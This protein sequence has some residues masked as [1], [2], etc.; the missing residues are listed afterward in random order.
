MT[1]S[2][3]NLRVPPQV[4]EDARAA[5]YANRETLA[6]RDDARR[7][8]RRAQQQ[9]DAIRRVQPDLGRQRGGQLEFERPPLQRLWRR[10]GGRV[11][12]PVDVGV[13]WLATDLDQG[14]FLASIQSIHDEAIQNNTCQLNT[15]NNYIGSSDGS[16][17][18]VIG[19]GS[20]YVDSIAQSPELFAQ[21]AHFVEYTHLPLG[22][23]AM[24]AIIEIAR[25]ESQ[26]VPDPFYGWQIYNLRSTLKTF[27]YVVAESSVQLI[28]S[29]AGQPGF[30]PPQDQWYSGTL[31]LNRFLFYRDE[32]DGLIKRRL[33][34]PRI[35]KSFTIYDRNAYAWSHHGAAGYGT[36]TSASYDQFRLYPNSYTSITAEEAEAAYASYANGGTIPVLGYERQ[37]VGGYSPL[38]ERG[39]FGVIPD[40]LTTDPSTWAFTELERTLDRAPAAL[41]STP[42]ADNQILIAY[43][44]HGGTFCRDSLAQLGITL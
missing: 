21:V 41:A 7:A 4:V 42:G 22:D 33:L 19:D 39:Q 35:R 25:Y 11:L 28:R 27:F 31:P 10:R 36:P 16:Q 37:T 20:T 38:T 32:A 15:N 8:H 26:R 18:L 14:D 34:V 12:R 24:I 44:Y 17:W 3:V 2:R 1:S 5:Q 13:A 6:A 30:M 23:N 29:I 9:V 43:D 40:A